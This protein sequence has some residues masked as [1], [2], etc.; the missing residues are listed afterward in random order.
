MI[1][2]HPHSEQRGHDLQ[3]AN[4][5]RLQLKTQGFAALCELID[6]PE[7]AGDPRCA[8]TRSRAA[9]AAELVPESRSAL[10]ART[11]LTVRC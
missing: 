8:T 9:H 1:A 2:S 10:A 11:A 4:R 5:I 3:S 6:R 7:L